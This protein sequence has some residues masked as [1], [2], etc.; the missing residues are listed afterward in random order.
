MENLEKLLPQALMEANLLQFQD[1]LKTDPPPDFSPRYRRIRRRLLSDPFR[2]AR[3]RSRPLWRR[4]LR[5]AAGILLTC[6][7]AIG[8]LLAASPTARAAVLH[9]LR[10]VTEDAILY[11]PAQESGGP[12]LPASWRPAAPPEGWAVTDVLSTEAWSSWS[13]LGPENPEGPR[14]RITCAAYSP[15]SGVIQYYELPDWTCERL[16]VSGY[17]A[18]YYQNSLNPTV[19]RLVW[20]GEGGNLFWVR[21]ANV[22]R[23]TLLLMAEGMTF[24]RGPRLRWRV[25]C[26]PED[27]QRVSLCENTGE[28]QIE[29]LGRG[30]FLT[31]RYIVQPPC[32]LSLP[33]REGEAAAVRGCPAQFWPCIVPEQERG[34]V[35]S[36]QVAGASITIGPAFSDDELAVLTWEEAGTVFLLQ[37]VMEREEL[38]QI[39]ESVKGERIP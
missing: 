32:P 30:D 1:A 14:G 4:A 35:S 6:A 18:D 33:Q 8:A 16:T 9:W 24:Y 21:G 39:A 19:G 34:K 23:D 7:V 31:F 10:E 5:T 3:R 15:G 38:L 28:G 37:G 12:A 27:Y 11:H 17:P 26:P 29:W 36:S 2:W 20:E 22:D 25:E 13:L